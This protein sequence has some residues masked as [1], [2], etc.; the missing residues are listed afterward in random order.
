MC[1]E[2]KYTCRTCGAVFGASEIGCKD[3]REDYWDV[4]CW[5]CPKCGRV[6]YPG[7]EMIVPAEED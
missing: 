2:S 1:K 3:V 5:V 6:E 4:C 7:I